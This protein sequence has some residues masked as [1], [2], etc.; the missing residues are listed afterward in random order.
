MAVKS[1]VTT[2]EDFTGE[3]P[4]RSN[5]SALW[6]LNEANLEAGYLA[7]SSGK[8]RHV[9]IMNASGTSASMQSGK[10][11]RYLRVN[12]VNPT[13]EKNYLVAT[14]DGSFFSSLGEKIVVGGWV[15]PTTYSIG[16]N[17]IPLFNT[18]QGPGNPIFYISLYQGRYRLMLYNASGTLIYDQTETPTI[19]LKNGG[20]YFIG[21]VINVQSNTVQNIVC[22]RSD[23]ATWIS[24]IRNFTG[25]I[26]QSCTADIVMCMHAN[27]YYFAGGIDDLFFETATDL[28]IEDLR[29]YFLT[30]Q[31][32]N[33]ADIAAE[34]DAL[35]DPGAVRLKEISG[36]YP[37]SGTLYTKAVDCNLAGNGRVS[38][39]SEYTAGVTAISNIETST[40]DDLLNWSVWQVIGDS[41]E[42]N[43]PNKQYIKFKVTLTTTDITKTPKLVDIQ[44]HD[45]PKSPYEKLGFARPVVL[46][47]SGAWESVLEN[48]FDIMV[49]S[50]IN[51]SDILEFKIP[52]HDEKRI[53]LTNE[54]LVQ[55]VKDIYRIRTISDE[56]SVDGKVITQVYAEASFYDLAFSEDK[57]P[58]DFNAQAASYPMIYALQNTGWSVG[59]ITV[60]TKRTWQS[61]EKNTLSILRAIQNIYGGDLV[62]D[63][64]NKLVHLLAFSGMDSGALFAY[65][66]NMKSI[67]RVVDT[68]GLITKL[69]A[70]GKDGMTF[71]S[72][73]G[74]KAYIE[75]YSYSSEARVSTL[76]CSS[77]S[78][79]YQMLEFTQMRLAEYAKPR[80]SYVLSAMDLSVLTGWEHEAWKLGDIVTVHDSELNLTIKTRIIRRQYNLQEPWRT[81]LE[82]STK[83]RELGDASA[84]WDKAADSLSSADLLDRQEIK[85]LVPFNHLLNSRGDDGFLYWVNSGFEVDT[86]NGMSGDA[87]FKAT[88]MLGMTKSLSQTIHPATRKNYTF[89]TQIAS[90]N[91]QKGSNG[92]IGIEV[93]IEYED[94]TTETRFIDLF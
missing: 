42:L 6:K 20:W 50:E 54:K 31:F 8:N 57:L 34:V 7:D 47:S 45:I 16:Q 44:L 23:G 67:K 75:D 37:F 64:T 85:D 77:F 39:T 62:F 66:K 46:A 38:V 82:L 88:G 15:N 12:V 61:T 73:N 51:G 24:P 52:F 33:G 94:G 81:V 25:I 1:I 68:R 63:S 4:K 43:S 83:I 35:I 87:S 60:T 74:S 17:F 21:S 59:Q 69:Y 53:S 49:T 29:E 70:Y 36:N 10:L 92:Q 22:D 18:R 78:N 93:V 27:Q 41:G 91:L 32:A 79:P 2:Q 76:D 65:K 90:E 58:Q 84:Q 80:I 55:I 9:Q 89:S 26:N 19:I 3:F 71:A 30:T 13:T 11:G 86:A 5:I 48:A 72:I 14:N 40:S 28:N 56:K